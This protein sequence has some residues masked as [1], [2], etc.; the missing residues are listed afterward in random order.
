VRGVFIALTLI[1]CWYL[2]AHADN[3]EKY[4]R[5]ILLA[6]SIDLS[7][8]TQLN[9]TK[10]DRMKQQYQQLFFLLQIFNV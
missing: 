5:I 1:L 10:M 3:K 8:Q 6:K 2:S 7:V 4:N 9:F